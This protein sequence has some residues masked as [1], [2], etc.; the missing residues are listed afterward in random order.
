MSVSATI[1]MVGDHWHLLI[2]FGPTVLGLVVAL[3]QGV[4]LSFYRDLS[5]K[6][7]TR[8]V[9][10]RVHGWYRAGPPDE[11]YLQGA[12]RKIR[13]VQRAT[14]AIALAWPVIGLPI[15][16]LL[17]ATTAEMAR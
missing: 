8:P 17:A 14:L 15:A 6:H 4:A 11:A 9:W 7:N 3:A 2:V 16:M 5:F 1:R 13:Q 12:G 10:F